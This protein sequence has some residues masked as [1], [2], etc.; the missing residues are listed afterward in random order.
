[1]TLHKH[2]TYNHVC[3]FGKEGQFHGLFRLVNGDVDYVP[4]VEHPAFP[5]FALWVEAGKLLRVA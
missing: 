5:E 2:P 3:V 4:A 1:M